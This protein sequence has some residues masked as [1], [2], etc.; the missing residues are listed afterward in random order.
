MVSH[1]NA[2]HDEL[3]CKAALAFFQLVWSKSRNDG[4]DYVFS[5]GPK[6]SRKPTDFFVDL[7]SIVN[8]TPD[9][10]PDCTKFTFL[11]DKSDLAKTDAG[12][13][14]SSPGMLFFSVH[15]GNVQRVVVPKFAPK[16]SGPTF[17]SVVQYKYKAFD[18]AEKRIH[19]RLG[20]HDGE[21]QEPQMLSWAMLDV[22]D[23][24][25]MSLWTR[26]PELR[27]DFGVPISGAT[28]AKVQPVVSKLLTAMGHTDLDKRCFICFHNDDAESNDRAT[29]TALEAAGIVETVLKDAM[30][31]SW[32]LTS[33]GQQ[34]LAISISVSKPKRC[35]VPRPD[36]A[37]VEATPF[38]LA[39]V[40]KSQGWTCAVKP[41]GRKKETK[42]KKTSALSSKDPPSPIDY[43]V[44]GNKTWWLVHDQACFKPWYMRAL[45]MTP[46]DVP[47]P[48]FKSEKFYECLM[49][50][51]PL[52]KKSRKA[53]FSIDGA[54]QPVRK[55][56]RKRAKASATPPAIPSDS[57]DRAASPSAGHESSSS[58]ESKSESLKASSSSSSSESSLPPKKSEAP[59]IEPLAE[60][61]A[62]ASSSMGGRRS[63]LETTLYWK[64]ARFTEK[65]KYG[66]TCGYEAT[67]YVQAHCG[68]NRCTRTLGFGKHGDPSEVL[69]KLKWWAARGLD[70]SVASLDDHQALPVE[71]AV[72][73]PP[74][75]DIEQIVVPIKSL[76]VT[77]KKRFQDS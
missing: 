59:I 23:F 38:E 58:S 45:L 56:T 71:P 31:T 21:A 68:P 67:C 69:H 17:V 18:R 36:I 65:K 51:V 49:N 41:I 46:K 34:H 32:K 29:L 25:T 54:P 12:E 2:L 61:A 53:K 40:L 3:W 43:V 73:L 52:E 28:D 60:A 39:H 44:G 27:Y 72:G 64:S 26:S 37:T 66:I 20:G 7:A 30:S 8:P 50:G 63:V 4:A 55:R 19:L 13:S 76:S 24:A 74:L 16:V 57:S 9:L 1:G 10:E 14:D 47:I 15:R 42:K 35:L 77:G 5:L 11:D 33:F 62:K 48:H 75:S 70:P 6:L 22:T